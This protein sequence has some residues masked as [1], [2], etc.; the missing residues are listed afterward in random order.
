MRVSDSPVV[1]NAVDSEQTGADVVVF[2]DQLIISWIA[3]ENRNIYLT[4]ITDF[5]AKPESKLMI[6]DIDGSW[7]RGNVLYN[8]QNSPVYGIVYDA[9][10]KGG[11]GFNRY[12]SIS[13]GGE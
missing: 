6:S 11:S 2:N 1:T 9:G 12:I 5:N 7:V 10:S 3:E 8:Q 13:L 4:R